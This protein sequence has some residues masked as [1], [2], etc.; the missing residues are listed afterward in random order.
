MTLFLI[1]LLM[2]QDLEHSGL[3]GLGIANG[4]ANI[5]I[6][7]N[8]FMPGQA[9]PGCA[10][11][12]QVGL[13]RLDGTLLRCDNTMMYPDTTIWRYLN[14]ISR[15]HLTILGSYST[16]LHRDNVATTTLCCGS[17]NTLLIC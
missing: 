2:T 9:I 17:D 5:R 6:L 4:V 16:V 14:T 1:K 12:G 13:A 7:L 15:R 8:E 3:Q 11:A 10:G